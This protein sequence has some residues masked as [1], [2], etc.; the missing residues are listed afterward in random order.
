VVPP[1]FQRIINSVRRGGSNNTDSLLAALRRLEDFGL[2]L[3]DATLLGM[4]H[5]P[6]A[7]SASYR[8]D[9]LEP[10]FTPS[11]HLH[12]GNDIFA[13][14]GTPLRAP[15]DGVV[16][17]GDEPVGGLAAYVTIPDGTYFYMAHM[18]ASAK[19]LS[20]GSP[21]RQGQI[22]GYV[23]DS[24]D[25]QGGSPHCHFEIH[26]RGGSAVDPKSTLDGWLTE[27]QNNVTNLLSSY[28]RAAPRALTSAGLIRRF[29]AG[30]FAGP[31]QPGTGSLL[32][33]STSN[34]SGSAL[35]LAEA[36]ATRAAQE[37]DWADFDDGSP[38]A[39]VT[40]QRADDNAK[41][42]LGPLTPRLL[43]QLLGDSAG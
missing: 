17:Y 10:R 24:G 7:G 28:L 8:D 38:N 32:W 30:A 41:A 31:S 14:T 11:F 4:G 34:P 20:S 19:G 16:R 12:Q 3:Q 13:T 6:V 23:G 9:W 26:P 42:V 18:S 29:D 36:E 15:Y 25:A 21:V 27:A 2:T 35:G 33:A 40:W 43:A 39:P 37:Y 22:V 1:E 5:F